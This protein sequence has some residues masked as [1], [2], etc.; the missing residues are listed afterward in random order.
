MSIPICI[1]LPGNV[2][3]KGIIWGTK[4]NFFHFNSQRHLKVHY[5]GNCICTHKRSQSSWYVYVSVMYSTFDRDLKRGTFCNIYFTWEPFCLL[6]HVSFKWVTSNL[7]QGGKLCHNSVILIF[8][9]LHAYNLKLKFWILAL[10]VFIAANKSQ[11]VV[12]VVS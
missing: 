10:G 6:W 9:R 3:Q 7:S 1:R 8:H 11:S 12:I 5:I 4:P 2:I